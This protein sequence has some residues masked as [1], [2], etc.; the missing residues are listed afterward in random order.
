MTVLVIGNEAR[1]PFPIIEGL[2]LDNLPNSIII[3]IV[4]Y[5]P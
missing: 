2:P 5:F 3:S 4:I 1:R